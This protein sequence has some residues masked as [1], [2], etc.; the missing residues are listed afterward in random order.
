MKKQLVSLLLL[1]AACA[2]Q[3]DGGIGLETTVDEGNEDYLEENAWLGHSDFE[4]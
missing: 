1:A 3:S 2:S 4:G